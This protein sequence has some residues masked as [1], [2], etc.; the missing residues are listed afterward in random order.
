M[1]SRDVSDETAMRAVPTAV[2]AAASSRLL[3]PGATVRTRKFQDRKPILAERI[4]S[5][6]LSVQRGRDHRH[7][8]DLGRQ[9]CKADLGRSTLPVK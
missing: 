4:T 8:W 2:A 7:R 1:T 6:D 3:L 9:A 5:S